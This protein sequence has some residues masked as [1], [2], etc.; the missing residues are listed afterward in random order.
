MLTTPSAITLDDI[1][2]SAAFTIKAK[3]NLAAGTYSASVKITAEILASCDLYCKTGWDAV[4]PSIVSQPVSQTVTAGQAVSFTVTASGTEPLSYQSEEDGVNIRGAAAASPALSIANVQASDA[5]SYAVVVS[6]S[7]GSVT[8]SA[9]TLTVNPPP[10]YSIA[11]IGNQI[12]TDLTAGYGSGTQ[13]SK[14]I[15]ISRTGTGNLTNIGVSLSGGNTDSF[16]LTTPSAI[17]L[18]D[19][20]TSAVFTIKAKDNLAVGTYS[21]SVKITADNMAAVTFTVKQVVDAAAVQPSI[22]TQPVSQTATAGQAVGFTVTAS[23]TEPLSYQWKKR[24]SEYRRSCRCVICI[25]HSKCAGKR[26]RK[27]YSCGKQFS[28]QC[29]KQCCHIDCKSY[30][31]RRTFR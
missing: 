14:T 9:V 21:A 16:M 13:E 19:I 7:V 17:T 10:T 3:D 6:N 24:W 12:L 29:N 18:D 25:K 23:G 20:T 11:Q 31:R 4:Q 27:L 5:G 15:T 22:V 2:T 8:S 28:G 30:I 26:C 1:T